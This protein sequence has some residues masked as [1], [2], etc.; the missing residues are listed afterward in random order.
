MKEKLP[1]CMYAKHGAYY[2]VK[3]NKWIRLAETLPAALREYARRIEANQ[4]RM[5]GLLDRWFT[6]V[7]VAAAT[8][9]TYKVVVRQLAKIFAEYEPS[10]VTAREIMTVMHHHRKKPGMANHMRTVLIGA[11]DIGFLEGIVER[12]VARDVRPFTIAARDRY[13]T[14]AEFDAIADEAQPTMRVIMKLCFHTGQ[15]ISDIIKLRYSD[16]SDEGITFKQKKTGNRLLVSW[17]PELRAVVEEARK[18]HSGVKGMTLLHTQ[19]G[20]QYSYWTIRTWWDEART[21]AGVEDVHIHDIRAKSGTDADSA[22]LDS[23]KLLGHKSESSHRRYLR[24]KETPIATP[25][26]RKNAA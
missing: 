7:E 18:L 23:K 14:D 17:S 3:K 9:A 12:N 25:A 6:D 13:I 26:S 11:L 15:R 8:R 21:A 4:D 20:T 1:P 19:K 24:S 5:P 2:L 10:A 22:G 16:I